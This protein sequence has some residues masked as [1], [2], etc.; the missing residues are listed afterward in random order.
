MLH[1]PPFSKVTFAPKLKKMKLAIKAL[2]LAVPVMIASC[3][4]AHESKTRKTVTR[5]T[6]IKSAIPTPQQKP[7]V[8]NVSAN[9]FKDLVDA[10]KGIVLD[11]RTPGETS[12]GAIKGASFI[13]V[14]DRQFAQKVNMMQKDQPIY[15]YCLS[16]ARST[17]AA[18]I[19]AS[20]GFKEIY[21][22]SGG[23]NTWKR[24]G[25]ALTKPKAGADKNIKQLTLAEF[26]KMLST[27]QPVLVDFH[28]EWCS[29]CRKMA[30]IVD[31]LAKE[32]KGNVTVLRLDVD[33]SKE[34]ANFYKIQ[35]VPV[36][37][38]Y[39]DGKEVWRHSGV[40]TK[41]DLQK[42]MNNAAKK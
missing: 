38:I 29:P 6:E 26:N 34:V 11:V 41:E 12:Q 18:K 31:E 32:N 20:N 8:Q 27:K 30:P 35:G 13:N 2:L 3:A 28:T 25:Y 14:Y 4:D 37:I 24:A 22:L 19:M 40:L 21:N 15:I 33:K 39:V 5:K 17:H 36:F 7:V 9:Q 16:G 23:I 42:E 1:I 10:G